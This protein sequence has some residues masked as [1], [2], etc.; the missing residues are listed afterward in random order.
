MNG[1]TP[2]DW[3]ILTWIARGLLAALVLC[4]AVGCWK[5]VKKDYEESKDD[6]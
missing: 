1:L 3:Q 6:E 5:M 4:I 2:V